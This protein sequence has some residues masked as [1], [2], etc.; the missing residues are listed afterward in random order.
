MLCTCFRL[1]SLSTIFTIA[2]VTFP[3]KTPLLVKCGRG[4][5]RETLKVSVDSKRSSSVMASVTVLVVT[6]AVRI[7]CIG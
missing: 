4:K 7:I 6:P 3:G 5:P 2:F 1:P